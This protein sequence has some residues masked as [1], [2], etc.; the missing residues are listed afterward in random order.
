MVSQDLQWTAWEAPCNIQVHLH[1]HQPHCYPVK[2]MNCVKRISHCLQV[3][4]EISS[5]EWGLLLLDEVH[6]VPAQMFRKV[7]PLTFKMHMLLH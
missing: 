5:R 3:M 2:G 1:E 6:V 7:W 4:D